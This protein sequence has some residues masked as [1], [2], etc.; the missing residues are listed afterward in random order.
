MDSGRAVTATGDTVTSVVAPA[1][2]GHCCSSA[3]HTPGHL[4]LAH[5]VKGQILQAR[6]RPL[7]AQ[8]GLDDAGQRAGP[9][10]P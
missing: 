1:P 5:L 2:T 4:C 7:G 10:G 9:T 8:D 3:G 6:S